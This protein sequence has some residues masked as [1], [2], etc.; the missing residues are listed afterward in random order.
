M[1]VLL[2]WLTQLREPIVGHIMWEQTGALAILSPNVE[3]LLRNLAVA[4]AQL[5]ARAYIR[6]VNF[7]NFLV[8]LGVDGHKRSVT[9]LHV[10]RSHHNLPVARSLLENCLSDW[11]DLVKGLQQLFFII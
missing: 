2:S 5:V 1:E 3:V 11:R 10:R 9:L 4:M 7:D 8:L 6:L